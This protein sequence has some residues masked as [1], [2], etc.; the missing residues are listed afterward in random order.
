MARWHELSD[1]LVHDALAR[2]GT[3]TGEHG[4]GVGK[5]GALALEHPDLVPLYRGLKDLFDPNGIMNPGKVVPIEARPT[6]R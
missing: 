6:A 2:G 5:I 4:I 3:C 1:A